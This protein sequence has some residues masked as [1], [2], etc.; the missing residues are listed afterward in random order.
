MAGLKDR[1]R[2]LQARGGEGPSQ[3][4]K[5]IETGWEIRKDAAVWEG[6]VRR[7][8]EAARL[9][10]R[11]WHVEDPAALLEETGMDPE[12]PEGWRASGADCFQPGLHL[13]LECNGQLVLVLDMNLK[14]G[15]TLE[16]F[17]RTVPAEEYVTGKLEQTLPGEFN[18]PGP[19]P[20][21]AQIIREGSEVSY[22]EM[23]GWP[24]TPSWER[25]ETALAELRDEIQDGKLTLPGPQGHEG[26]RL[27]RDVQ[28]LWEMMNTDLYVVTAAGALK[29]RAGAA[30]S[31]AVVSQILGWTADTPRSMGLVVTLHLQEEG[32]RMTQFVMT[33]ILRDPDWMGMCHVLP[34]LCGLN[35]AV[36]E[37]RE[38]PGR[39]GLVVATNEDLDEMD[40][41]G[42]QDETPPGEATLLRRLL[43]EHG[44]LGFQWIPS[45]ENPEPRG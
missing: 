32:L 9:A 30:A 44:A 24:M 34:M 36:M 19:A 13:R 12:R 2:R 7:E 26:S 5:I 15:I 17:A 27:E 33:R 4:R 20:G 43:L 40:R 31:P 14:Q 28:S 35:T 37:S 25:V 3:G 1:S 11:V 23:T 22:Q 10:A 39:P 21:T 8:G 41:L 18:R 29:E 6:D 38:L 42:L 45:S 16:E